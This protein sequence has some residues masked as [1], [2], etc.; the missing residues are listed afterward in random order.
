MIEKI[1]MTALLIAAIGY[2]PIGM[3]EA[4]EIKTDVAKVIILVAFIG[5]LAVGVGATFWRIWS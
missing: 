1:Q 5:G 2:I 4:D 3:L